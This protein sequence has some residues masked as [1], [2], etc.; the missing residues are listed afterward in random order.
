MTPERWRQ[1][2]DLFD[3]ALR[4][5]PAEREAWL[6]RACGGDD[7]LRAEVDRLLAQD[8]RA[9]RD[10]FLT[11]PEPAGRSRIRRASWPPPRRSPCPAAGPSRSI[12]TGPYRSTTPAAS[13]PRRR[14]PRATGRT[15]RRDP[16]GG[17]GAAAR[18]ADDLYRL[19]RWGSRSLEAHPSSGSD[20]LTLYHLDCDRR[21][22][23]G[24]H[25]A[26]SRA[27]GPSRW[28]GSRPWSWA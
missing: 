10:G 19:D 22:S 3:A 2:D 26:C 28:P 4:V 11:P 17:A 14:S 7:D 25:R 16:A 15:R 8:E 21:G 5:E 12:A 1:I 6:R 9:D 20:D 27:G 18:A 13:P 23:W 24:R